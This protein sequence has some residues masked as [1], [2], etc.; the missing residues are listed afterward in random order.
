MWHIDESNV[1][2]YLVVYGVEVK[3]PIIRIGF[4]TEHTYKE[5]DSSYNIH[6]DSG[7][8]YAIV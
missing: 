4:I 8:W 3:R 1:M 2:L 6:L 7:E 5:S